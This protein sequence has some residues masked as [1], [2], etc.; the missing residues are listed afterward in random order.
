M[1]NP[2]IQIGD[3]IREMTDDEYQAYVESDAKRVAEEE[4]RAAENNEPLA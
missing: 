3:V 4:A 1:S 2:L